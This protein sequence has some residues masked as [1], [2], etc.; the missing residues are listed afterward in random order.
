MAVF[1]ANGF[2]AARMDDIAREAGVSKGAIY[3]YFDSKVAV[4]KALIAREVAP[5]ARQA[6]A[7]ALAGTHEPVHTLRQLG[8][9]VSQRLLE[10]RSFAVPRIVLSVASRFPEIA[11]Y[12]RED[13][14]D[15]GRGAIR[16]LVRAGIEQGTFRPVDPEAAVR[17]VVGPI[18]F[19][20]LYSHVL[21][22]QPPKSLKQAID[23]HLDL[24]LRALQGETP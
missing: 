15:R 13:V 23:D 14:V 6:E 20:A 19:I 24:V 18:L 16:A 12:Y 22:G 17:A 4:L 11:D 2:D 1:V 5:I 21:G 9:I 8:S 3:L 10:T 7:V